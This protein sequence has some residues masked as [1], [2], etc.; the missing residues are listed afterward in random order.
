MLRNPVSRLAT[1]VEIKKPSSPLTLK[2]PYRGKIDSEVYGPSKDLGGGIA[3]LQSQIS[4]SYTSLK[5]KIQSRMESEPIDLP[6]IDGVLIIGRLDALND[7]QTRSFASFRNYLHGI[8]IVTF[9]EI[10]KRL[11]HMRDALCAD[12]PDII[13]GLNSY[14]N[15]NLT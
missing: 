1:L 8:T 12:T 14:Q 11:T 5:T 3:Q 2:K 7:N 15:P 6:S 9:D 10:L 4:S 13:A